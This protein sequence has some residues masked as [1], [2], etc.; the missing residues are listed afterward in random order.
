MTP[1]RRHL[2]IAH[3]SDLHAVVEPSE[4]AYGQERVVAALLGDIEARDAEQPIDL[5]V[6]SGDLAWDGSGEALRRGRELLLD[7]LRERYP[8]TPIVLAPGNHDV[9]RSEVD[10][11]VDIG[12]RTALTTREAVQARLADPEHREQARARLKGWDQMAAEWD[13]GLAEE[14]LP[15]YGRAYRFE[16]NGISVAIGSFDSAWRSQG[17]AEDKGHLIVGADYV[18]GFLAGAADADVAIVTFH[19]PLEWLADFDAAAVRVALEESHTLVLTGHDHIP[20]PT[21]ELSTRGAALYCRAPCSYAD[22]DYANGYAIIDVEPDR[23]RTTVQLRRWYSGRDR[24]G[25]DSETATGGSRSFE[26]PISPAD[27]KPVYHVPDTAVL[28]PFG[29]LAKEQSVIAHEIDDGSGFLVSDFMVPPRFWPVPHTEVFDNTVDP[30]HRPAEVDPLEVMD[31]KRALIVSGPRMSGVSTALLWLLELH[32]RQVGSHVPAH[33]K[34]D[35]RF[36]LGRVQSQIDIARERFR[37]EDPRGG[38][39][40][41]IIAVDDVEPVDSRALGRMIRLLR[42]NEDVIVVLGC[43]D[44]ADKTVARALQARSIDAGRVYLGPFGRR[45]TRQLVS[46]IAGAESKELVPKVLQIVKRQQLPRNPLNLAA[47]IWV[48][49]REPTLTSVNESGLLQSFVAVL[50]ENPTIQD[51]E[52]LHMD[53]RRREHL[54][55]EIARHIVEKNRRRLPRT[56]IEQLVLDYYAKIGWR[57]GSAGN[58]VE[59]LIRRKVLIEDAEGVGFRYRALLHLFAAKATFDDAEFAQLVHGDL[60]RF[61]PVVR[62]VAGLK[63]SDR[64]TLGEVAAKARSIRLEL[65]AAVEVRQF[66]LIKDEHGWSTIRDL[67]DVRKLVKTRPQAPS[68]QELDEIDHESMVETSEAGDP[69]PFADPSFGRAVDQ[70]VLASN[71]AASV[72]QS[73][74][75]VE[76]VQLRSE[77]MREVIA[78]WA[79]MTVLFAMEEDMTRGLHE[80]MEPLFAAIEDEGERNSRIEHEARLVVVSLMSL[81]LYVEVGSIHHEAVLSSL[82]N[83]DEFMAQT[84]YALFASM[85]YAMLH[86]PGWPKRLSELYD[87]HG[88]HP[89]VS[90]VVR[91]WTL[92]EYHSDDLPEAVAD[93]VEDLLVKILTPDVPVKMRKRAAQG[94][95]VREDLRDA[96]VK[97]RWGRRD[98]TPDDEDEGPLYPVKP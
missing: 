31:G 46:R 52:G 86:F 18:R 8:S 6:F 77:V 40:P 53:Y 67:N 96:R 70:L 66:D 61:A 97:Y 75:L 32:Y 14:H 85:L 47:L 63:R 84:A 28:K 29:V 1:S 13:V 25:P 50:L 12:L 19:H 45:E 36:S 58:L 11:V 17:G 20:D 26:W 5:L 79:V 44:D 73:S 62:H 90:E 88:H 65:A 59:S 23:A 93:A 92:Q 24:F 64:A 55:Q 94:S 91:R 98:A 48:M 68:E 41:V 37:S 69:R 15:P 34:A 49:T 72:L 33:V 2:R 21:L 10:V 51:P 80:L 76:D 3:L 4:A 89:I 87:R 56:E 7:P 95:K 9:D 39:P 54:L 35:P 83:D 78:G 16:R 82:L 38:D 60:L 81:S 57:S 30:A 42:E 74:E 71:L 43:H 22:A 27:A